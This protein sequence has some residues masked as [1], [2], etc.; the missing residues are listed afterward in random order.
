MAGFCTYL[1]FSSLIEICN[2]MYE[3]REEICKGAVIGA[4]GVV[5]LMFTPALLASFGFTSG[6]IAAGSIAAK[7]MSWLGIVY[8]GSVF[9][10]LQSLGATGLTWLTGGYVASFGGVMG[11]MLSAI[12]NQSR[13]NTT[14]T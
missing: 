7:I 1:F 13:N 9:A 12:C 4:G 5:T 3:V 14:S 8:P 6:G 11:W 10:F 2:D